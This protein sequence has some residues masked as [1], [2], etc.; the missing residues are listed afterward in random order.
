[1]TRLQNP[2]VRDLLDLADG[3]ARQGGRPSFRQ[4]ALRRAVS[5]AYYALLHALCTVCSDGLVRWNRTDLVDRT[6]RALDHGTAR[7]RMASIASGAASGA[8]IK[9]VSA[10][11]GLL[12]DHRNDADYE[13][14]RV[15][16]SRVRTL[17]LIADAREAIDLLSALDEDAR[18]RLSVELLVAKGR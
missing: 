6:Y 5:T 12:Q 14:P 3:L 15:L 18:R 13:R 2:L 1:M 4:A 11:F 9:R 10:N 8:P 17:L 7:R 16:F